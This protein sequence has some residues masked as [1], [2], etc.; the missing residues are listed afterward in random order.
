MQDF[1]LLDSSDWF[2][3]THAGY[4]MSLHGMFFAPSEE[5]GAGCPYYRMLALKV[6]HDA[7]IKTWVSAEPVLN[8]DDVINFIELADYV[9]LLKIG[10]LN[11]H[12]SNIDWKAF[13]ERAVQTCKAFK[14]NYYIK[15]SLRAEM[16]RKK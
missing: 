4:E 3:V 6:A 10:K 16:E 1:D 7:G 5:P 13:G 15:D 14:R 11:Y 2:G 12:Q 8:S 9:D